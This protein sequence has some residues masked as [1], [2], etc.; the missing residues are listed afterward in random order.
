[1]CLYKQTAGKTGGSRSQTHAIRT[2]RSQF[3]GHGIHGPLF[4]APR[5]RLRSACRHPL[6]IL[7]N[8]R[9]SSPEGCFG[10]TKTTR[11]G[12][13]HIYTLS[14]QTCKILRV[15]AK[16]SGIC[17]KSRKP[18]VSFSKHVLVHTQPVLNPCCTCINPYFYRGEQ[19][20]RVLFENPDYCSTPQEFCGF[21]SSR[22]RERY[23]YII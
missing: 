2:I 1:M 5:P 3:S 12:N 13:I 7:Q 17:R 20:P 11:N 9:A 10:A 23:I 4:Y 19:K 8:Q 14:T 22:E 6:T 15:N 16:T 18:R 21:G